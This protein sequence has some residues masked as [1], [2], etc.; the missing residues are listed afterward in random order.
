MAFPPWFD[1]KFGPHTIELY[2]DEVRQTEFQVNALKLLLG[3]PPARSST[4]LDLCCGWGRHAVQLCRSG[5]RVV[6]LDGSMFF[7][8]RIGC[9][10]GGGKGRLDLVR[11]DMRSLPFEGGAVSAVVQM[12]TSFGYGDNPDDDALVLGEVNRVL[13]AGGVY[14]LDLINWE[15]ARGAFDGRFEESYPGFD[16]VDDCRIMPG[17]LLKVKRALLYKDGRKPHIYSFEIRMFDHESLTAL[18]RNAGLEVTETWGDFNRSDYRAESSYRMIM[19][20][21]KK[22]DS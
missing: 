13:R 15:L 4:V 17:D 18:L 20:C 14:L 3:P 9:P 12:Y 11:G 19:V 22:G 21:R 7:L 8:E 5:Y 1:S 10:S 2:Q 16:M 6:G